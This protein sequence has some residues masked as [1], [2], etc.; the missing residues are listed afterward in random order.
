MSSRKPSRYGSGSSRGPTASI[1]I[2]QQVI[3]LLEFL[4]IR[5]LPQSSRFVA[6]NLRA[7]KLLLQAL[8][9]PLKIW[10]GKPLL[11]PFNV[12]GPAVNA[13]PSQDLLVLRLTFGFQ[14]RN[15]MFPLPEGKS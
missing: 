14:P 9:A 13:L 1:R 15:V 7:S 3:E 10:R 11:S 12:I 5:S 8:K 4:G 6:D 2:Y